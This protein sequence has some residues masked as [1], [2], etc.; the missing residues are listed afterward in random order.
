MEKTYRKW[1]GIIKKIKEKI[2]DG[3]VRR[4]GGERE[5]RRNNR[6]RIL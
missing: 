1:Y 5:K 2:G 3:W 4:T 6:I